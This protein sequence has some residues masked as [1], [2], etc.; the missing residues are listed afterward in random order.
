MSNT[1]IEKVRAY[2]FAATA[3]ATL[4]LGCAGGATA[5]EATSAAAADAESDRVVVTAR[6]KE[7]D[8]L[9]VPMSVA[10]VSGEAL[11]KSGVVQLSEALQS[12]PAVSVTPTPVG[13]LMFIRGIGSGENQ[14]FEMSVG[15]FVDGVYYGR[16]R[17]SR[18]AFLDADRI[19]VLK[20]PQAILFGKN[21][22]GGALNITTRQPTDSLEFSLEQYIEPEFGTYQTTGAI[23]GPLTDTL[24][25]RLVARK[26]STDGYVENTFLG[27]DE[28]SRDEWVVR[29]V[30]Q[31]EPTDQF[32]ATFKGEYGDADLEGGRA[33]VTQA[34]PLLRTLIS[35]VDPN[36]EY[37]LNYV[38][39]GPGTRPFFNEEHDRNETYNGTLT[40]VWD[41]SGHEFTSITSYAGYDVDYKFDTDFT[42]LDFLHQTWDQHWHSWAQ[43][44]RVASTSGGT[45]EYQAG[46]FWAQERL[47]NTRILSIDFAQT[48]LPFGAGTRVM[49]FGQDTNSWSLFGEGTWNATKDLAVVLG[50]RY[51]DDEKSMDK[52]L[53][54]ANFGSV[55]P[56]PA[57]TV[58]TALRLGTPYSRSG[59]ERGTD[60]NALALTVRYMPGDFMYYAS[61]SQGFKAG[62]FD[63]N[64]T[65][66]ILDNILFEDETVTSVELGLKG[67]LLDGRLS[68]QT[69]AFQSEYDDLQVSIFDGVASLIVGN[70]A[71]ATSKGVEFEGQFAA[72]S[73]LNFSL[74]A[75]YLDSSYDSYAAGPCA[76]GR[77]AT[78]NL[79]GAT[80]PYAPEWSGA[81]GAT[82]DGAIG[83]GWTYALNGRLF[84]SSSFFTAGD[85]DPFVAQ[86]DFTKLDASLT[87]Y[88]PNETWS[89]SLVGKNLTDET[90]AHFGDDV[91]LSNILGN[92]YQQYVDPPRTIAVQARYRY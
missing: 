23:S 28:P 5:Q 55:V 38:K 14:G 13:D 78:C 65:T 50:Y 44:L 63:E 68:I 39:S 22:I 87:F 58:F 48:P 24:S 90:T 89:F 86:D 4:A 92:N 74:S 37:V 40:A 3:T 69:A 67:E 8:L 7:E 45:F 11:E 19:E 31:W 21:T 27:T 9:E 41:A 80:L 26:Y 34:S 33:Q 53:H 6:R 70:A 73:N 66:G 54:W 36:A 79:T 12:V 17:S 30:L 42:P 75:T 72:T 76:F 52:T 77:G 43:E 25:G 56:N 51:T 81:L 16:G 60:N 32:T 62:G 61:V 57:L 35:Q 88:S 29:G 84:Y 91:P 10:V 20:G 2:A 18:H 85:L 49:R 47:K 64:D 82:Y 46:L 71:A 15:T 59:I 83:N 1:G